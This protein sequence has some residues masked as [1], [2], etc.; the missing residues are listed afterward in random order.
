MLFRKLFSSKGPRLSGLYWPM[1]P[2]RGENSSNQSWGMATSQV[3]LGQA[4]SNCHLHCFIPDPTVMGF[5]T[6]SALGQSRVGSCSRWIFIHGVGINGPG[7]LGKTKTWTPHKPNSD[8]CS[9]IDIWLKPYQLTIKPALDRSRSSL[10]L[11]YCHPYLHC[12]IINYT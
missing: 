3:S 7:R 8:C 6:R 9:E 4:R 12:P 1:F 2:K 5:N 10:N 11:T